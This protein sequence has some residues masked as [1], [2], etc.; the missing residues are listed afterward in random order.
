[1]PL[2]A[3]GKC[4]AGTPICSGEMIVTYGVNGSEKKGQSFKLC[5]PC[6]VFLRKGGN[7]IVQVRKK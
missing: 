7:K 6:A 3:V 4:E 5:G 2:E 1:M